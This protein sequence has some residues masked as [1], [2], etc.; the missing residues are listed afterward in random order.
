MDFTGKVALV[1]G[2]GRGI[3]L[4]IAE[5]FAQRG[6]TVVMAD[7]NDRRIERETRILSEKGL[8]VVGVV[9]DVTDRAAV[10]RMVA[11]ATDK[12]GPVDYLVNNAGVA[13]QKPFLDCTDDDW[14]WQVDTNFKGT[15]LCSQIWAR[16]AVRDNRGGAIVNIGS[17]S[18]F[19]YT[20]QHSIYSSAKA[21]IVTFTRDTAYELGPKGIRVNC[22][23][24]GPIETPLTARHMSDAEK[25]AYNQALRLGRWGFPADIA[26]TTAFLCSEEASFITG[27]T[28]SVAGGADLRVL[29]LSE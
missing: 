28:I 6:A 13:R 4:G 3:G 2:A 22:V 23:A 7:A 9:A 14:H 1:T 18:S 5:L 15:F 20:I 8:K 17:I 19:H 12:A 16:Q 29:N 21:A 11:E 10:E 26:H 27:Q 25:A 24:P